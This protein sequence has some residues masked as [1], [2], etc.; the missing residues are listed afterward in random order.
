MIDKSIAIRNVYVMLAYAYQA[1]HSEGTD[2][3]TAERFDFLQD[4]LAEILVRG[5]GSQIKRGLHRDYLQRRDEL[6]TVRGRIDISRTIATRSN[7]RALLM[8]EFDEYEP[9]TPH[10]QALKSVIVLL[11][12]QGDVTTPRRDALRRILP[13]LD[14]VTLIA[15]TSIRWNALTYHRANASYR[16]LL[17]VCE[18]IVR[19]LLPSQDAGTTKLTAWLSDDAMSRLYERFLRNYYK[20]HHPELSPSASTV[21]WDYDGTSASGARQL[22]AMITDVTLR[23]GQR[24]LIIDAKYYGH[25]MQIGMSNKATVHSANLYQVLAYAKN[26]DVNRDGSVSGL[27]LYARTEG[28]IQPNLDV[29][30][31][32]NRIGARTLDLNQPWGRLRVQLDEVTTWLSA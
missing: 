12:R 16:L 27:L 3:I 11:I 32:G 2:R 5:V 30:I 19:G 25:S 13:Y 29:V 26:A 7:T 31:Q 23:R 28:S 9:D 4:L 17:G 21:A 24:I 22:P 1:I 18:L 14:A 20:V 8:C 6:A 15:P 10:N